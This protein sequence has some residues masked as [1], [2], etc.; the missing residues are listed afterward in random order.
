MKNWQIINKIKIKKIKKIKKME[1]YNPQ[2][3]G[4]SYNQEEI[5][6]LIFIR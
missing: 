4:T 2:T 6:N 1:E 3:Q 5:K